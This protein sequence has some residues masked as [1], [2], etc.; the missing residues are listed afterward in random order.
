MQWFTL[1]KL[2]CP[3]LNSEM[4]ISTGYMMEKLQFLCCCG[5]TIV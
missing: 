2:W 4:S 3:R 5:I 1:G